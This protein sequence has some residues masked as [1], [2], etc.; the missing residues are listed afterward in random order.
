MRIIITGA[1]ILHTWA[2]SRLDVKVNSAPE[3]PNQL[4]L[5]INAIGVFTGNVQRFMPHSIYKSRLWK[6]KLNKTK[7]LQISNLY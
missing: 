3:Q 2:L 7:E 4:S 1:D 5:E 6:Y